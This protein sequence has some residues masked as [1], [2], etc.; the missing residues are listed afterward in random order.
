MTP[1][2]QHY[3]DDD[4][5]PNDLPLPKSLKWEAMEDGI[6]NKM[7]VIQARKRKR[8][9]IFWLFPLLL[10][11]GMGIGWWSFSPTETDIAHQPLS[12]LQMDNDGYQSSS[13]DA[14][15]HNTSVPATSETDLETLKADPSSTT[16]HQNST[17]AP[18]QHTTID[19]QP[20]FAEAPP[21]DERKLNHTL[22]TNDHKH[23]I[24]ST[25]DITPV[26]SASPEDKK[27]VFSA[28]VTPSSLATVADQIDQLK[29]LLHLPPI[30]I[31]PKIAEQNPELHPAKTAFKPYLRVQLGGGLNWFSGNYR[32][33]DANFVMLRQESEYADP[34]THFSARI[35]SGFAPNLFVGSGFDYKTYRTRLDTEAQSTINRLGSMVLLRFN[36][37]PITGDTTNQQFGDTMLTVHQL[38]RVR[39]YNRY[40]SLEIPVYLGYEFGFGR[41]N[42][43]LTGGLAASISRELE[44]RT[45]D[46]N[47]DVVTLGA[48]SFVSY[49]MGLTLA[50]A[51][52]L[53]VGYRLTNNLSV[54]LGGQYQR[55]ISNWMENSTNALISRPA[56]WSTDLGAAWKF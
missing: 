55:F 11:G 12:D 31:E 18:F 44:G 47:G 3:E 40:T 33:A 6:L 10:L 38:R 28:V 16:Q 26:I 49:R 1:P 9:F 19:S 37:D 54:T 8:R 2:D 23:D 20:A 50:A 30:A 41:F 51:G 43:A 15:D 39:H 52:G 32:G 45:F 13:A 27:S 21:F 36:E 5:F 42:L 34:G 7:A 4:L 17:S 46:R 53:R 56:V 14:T 25:K 24:E 29:Y 22:S 48:E 35:E